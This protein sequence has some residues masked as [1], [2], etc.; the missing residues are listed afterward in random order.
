MALTWKHKE[1]MKHC[2][3]WLPFDDPNDPLKDIAGNTWQK[4]NDSFVM[5]QIQTVDGVKCAYWADG[6]SNKSRLISYDADVP[7]LGDFYC[8]CWYKSTYIFNKDNTTNN[9]W[10]NLLEMNPCGQQEGYDRLFIAN[11][12]C[13]GNSY[14]S[15]VNAPSPYI[16]FAR[17]IDWSSWTENFSIFDQNW[18]YLEFFRTNGS[19]YIYVDGACRGFQASQNYLYDSSY[20]NVWRY[21]KASWPFG[22]VNN[23]YMNVCGNITGYIRHLRVFSLIRPKISRSF[24]YTKANLTDE[25]YYNPLREQVEDTSGTTIINQYEVQPTYTTAQRFPLL[26]TKQQLLMYNELLKIQNGD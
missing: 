16:R 18:H 3:I 8:D 5:P 21:S 17:Q 14:T 10:W 19:L 12:G 26:M 22:R 13:A 4:Y 24:G 1:I 20:Q 9:K 25:L 7:N 6:S 15:N 11:S 2:Y 23:S